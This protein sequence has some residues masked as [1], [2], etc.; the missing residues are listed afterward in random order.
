[1]LSRSCSRMAKWAA[2]GRE[3]GDSDDEEE[4]GD[5]GSAEVVRSSIPEDDPDYYCKVHDPHS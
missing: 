3:F 5:T 1:M 4:N 2:E